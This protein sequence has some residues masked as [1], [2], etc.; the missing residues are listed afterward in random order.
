MLYT[1]KI[2]YDLSLLFYVLGL[3]RARASSAGADGGGDPGGFEGRGRYAYPLYEDL[4]RAAFM[5]MRAISQDS[6]VKSCWSIKGQ[7]KFILHSNVKEIKK[8]SSL[9]EPL[10]T[11]LK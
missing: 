11:I 7:I 8:V 10:D 6:R 4:T 2:L 9:L 1:E 3:T 5:K